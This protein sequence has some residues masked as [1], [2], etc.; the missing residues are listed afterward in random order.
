MKEVIQTNTNLEVIGEN[1]P[2]AGSASFA[3]YSSFEVFNI[4]EEGWVAARHP[5]RPGDEHKVFSNGITQHSIHWKKPDFDN[6][7]FF[8]IYLYRL[9]R[10]I[11]LSVTP[12]FLVRFE[13]TLGIGS[14]EIYPTLMTPALYNSVLDWNGNAI[15]AK[16]FVFNIWVA[17]K[18]WKSGSKFQNY[19]VG[20]NGRNEFTGLCEFDRSHVLF[21]KKVN[22]T[23]EDVHNLSYIMKVSSNVF[24]G[25]EVFSRYSK[26]AH[27]AVDSILRLK[28]SLIYRTAMS[29]ARLLNRNHKS[30]F[31]RIAHHS[32]RV[33]I[34]R[35]RNLA[36]WIDEL[37]VGQ[38]LMIT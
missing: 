19:T 24:F 23:E 21:V 25:H 22:P 30:D 38:E 1:Q 13:G 32:A 35:K 14:V 6:E 33:L 7:L 20:I 3:S 17:H 11:S 16:H 28:D 36:K 34:A 15:L 12:T 5:S 27:E 9:S 26:V 4:N 10:H 8:E 18:D 37:Q 29:A 2:G 31:R